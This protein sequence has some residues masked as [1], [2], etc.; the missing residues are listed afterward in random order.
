M[1]SLNIKTICRTCLSE[2]GALSKIQDAVVTV[3]DS[4]KSV[5]EILNIFCVVEV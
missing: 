4:T 1:D 3:E 5:S 2:N